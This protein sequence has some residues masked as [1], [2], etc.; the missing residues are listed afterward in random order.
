MQAFKE[1]IAALKM[2]AGPRPTLAD[3]GLNEPVLKRHHSGL[4]WLSGVGFLSWILLWG[5]MAHHGLIV[6]GGFISLAVV[7][8]LLILIERSA[9]SGAHI[10]AYHGAVSD[11]EKKLKWTP[12]TSK[13]TWRAG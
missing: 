10:R 4:G 12:S 5:W 8:V 3:F 11:Y 6:V 2:A 7:T 13:R 9:L 1:T